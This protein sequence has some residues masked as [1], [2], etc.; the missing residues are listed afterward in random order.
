M[1]I[2]GDWVKHLIKMSINKW[3]SEERKREKYRYVHKNK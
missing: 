2:I 1:N 3:E